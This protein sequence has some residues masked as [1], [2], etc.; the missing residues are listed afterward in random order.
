[1]EVDGCKTSCSIWKDL[2]YKGVLRVNGPLQMGGTKFKF[3]DGEFKAVWGHLP[4]TNIGFYGCIRNFTYNSFYYNLGA[5]S[6]HFRSYPDC[7]YGVMQAVT[8]GIDSNF[9]VAVLVCVAILISKFFFQYYRK[10]QCSLYVI[11]ILLTLVDRYPLPV[12]EIVI[13]FSFFLDL[14]LES[15]CGITWSFQFYFD[16][17]TY[18]Y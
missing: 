2:T 9:L 13:H 3:N 5:P 11:E 14:I 4:P 16:S 7:N 18:T 6:D 15:H 17:Y 1:M 10:L 12:I 8:F